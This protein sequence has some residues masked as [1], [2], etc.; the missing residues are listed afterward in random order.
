MGIL[1][2]EMSMGSSAAPRPQP[3]ETSDLIRLRAIPA[4]NL[5]SRGNRIAEYSREHWFIYFWKE[6]KEKWQNATAEAAKEMV[7]FFNTA[8]VRASDWPVNRAVNLNPMNPPIVPTRP[9]VQLFDDATL[10]H[11]FE[12]LLRIGFDWYADTENLGNIDQ[13]RYIKMAGKGIGF[14][15]GWR[16][17]GQRGLAELREQGYLKQAWIGEPA[18]WKRGDEKQAGLAKFREDRHLGEAWNPFSKPEINERF[19]FRKGAN[20]DNDFYTVISVAKNWRTALCFPVI[21]MTPRLNL[22]PQ[23]LDVKM[24]WR[25]PD[26]VGQVEFEDGTE[27]RMITRSKVAMLLLDRVIFDTQ[28]RQ[29][30]EGGGAKSF[31]EE[32]V[33][34]IPGENVMGVAEFIRVHHGRTDDDGFSAVTDMAMTKQVFQTGPAKASRLL[35]YLGNDQAAQ[36]CAIKLRE[37]WSEVGKSQQVNIKWTDIGTG[38]ETL[39]DGPRTR[40]IKH[41]T[42]ANARIY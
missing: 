25:Y 15:V 11:Y 19:W 40:R 3:F 41:I 4:D 17:E 26:L 6:A 22:P 42:L 10:C 24:Q 30:A 8:F 35:I 7:R 23:P 29:I 20:A 21:K 9:F 28:A 2:L 32:G 14:E 39:L 33:S 36:D 1:A 31:P 5:F 18:F 27:Y 38:Y 37:A 34:A 13:A 16:G 12:L